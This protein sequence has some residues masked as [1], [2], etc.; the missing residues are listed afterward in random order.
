MHLYRKKQGPPLILPT[1]VMLAGMALGAARPQLINYQGRI[2]AGGVNFDG[3]G[4]FKFALVDAAGTTSYWSN[5]GTSTAGNEPAA[6]APLTV[7]KGQYT[8]LLGDAS[9]PA[10]GAI[11]DGIL[12]HPGR[13][14]RVWFND[15]VN[16]SQQLHPDQPITATAPGNSRKARDGQGLRFKKRGNSS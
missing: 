5:D 10:M 4:Q 3:S 8:V 9:L 1:L 13:F 6:A 16:G 12:D 2:A 14:L 15:S 7:S 11:P